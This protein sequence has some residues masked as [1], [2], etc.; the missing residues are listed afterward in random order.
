[1]HMQWVNM[2]PLG[3]KTMMSCFLSTFFH[4]CIHWVFFIFMTVYP[5]VTFLSSCEGNPSNISIFLSCVFTAS[6][7]SVNFIFNVWYRRKHF[8]HSVYRFYKLCTSPRSPDAFSKLSGSMIS[9][10]P[11]RDQKHFQNSVYMH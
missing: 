1:M 3:T 4:W 11:L 7:W 8:Q 10:P 6:G 2:Y 5:L 9:R